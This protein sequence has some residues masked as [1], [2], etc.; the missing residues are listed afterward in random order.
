MTAGAPYTFEAATDVGRKREQNEDACGEIETAGG[1]LLIVCDG[2][3]GHEAGEVASRI[4]VDAIGQI[5]QNSPADDPGERLK[6]GFL[7]ANQRI[8]V[9][10]E[11]NGTGSMGTTAVAAFVR[12]GEAWIAHVGDSRCYH[13]RDG[14]VLWRTADHT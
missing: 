3:G 9:H 13:L 14:A 4:A 8:L 11:R 7:V 1:V 5:F 2:M 10:A 6:A 12:G